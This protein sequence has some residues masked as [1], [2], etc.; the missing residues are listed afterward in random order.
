[1]SSPQAIGESCP[2]SRPSLPS[3]CSASRCSGDTT[4]QGHFLDLTGFQAGQQ[5]H[6]K[7]YYPQLKYLSSPKIQQL[8]TANYFNRQLH[9]K[10]GLLSLVIQGKKGK[11][12]DLPGFC[13]FLHDLFF[14][15]HALGFILYT[16]NIKILG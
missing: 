12:L 8:L 6:F 14:V 3:S 9:K 11:N 13:C 2:S 15:P 7:Y 5:T 10:C 4:A 1:M 16:H